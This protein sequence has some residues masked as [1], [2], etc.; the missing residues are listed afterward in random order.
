VVVSEN[1]PASLKALDQWIIWRNETRDGEPTKLPYSTDGPMAKSNDRSTWAPFSAALGV[2]QKGGYS[3]VGF[4]FSPEDEFCGIDLDGCRDPKTG[5]WSQWARDIVTAFSTYCELS[6]SESGVKLFVRGK[7]PL[8]SGKNVKLEGVESRGGKAA[9]I[10]VYDKLR[11][12]AVTGRRIRGMPPE[13]QGRQAL[14]DEYCAK[15]FPAQAAPAV[16]DFTGDAAVADRAR[17]YI[18]KIPPSV[19]GQGGHNQAWKAAC[20][21]VLHFGLNPNEAYPLLA[22]WNFGCQPPWSERELLHKLADADRQPGERGQLRNV[23]TQR[24][25]AVRVADP[26]PPARPPQSVTL[27]SSAQDYLDALK[28]GKQ[29]LISTGMADVDYAIGGGIERGEFVVIA[30]RPSHGKSAV[31]L[32]AAYSMAAEHNPVL[33]VSEEMGRLALGKRAIQ[34]ASDIP[35]EHW[36]HRSDV[37]KSH[38]AEHFEGREPIYI[39]E[40]CGTCDRAVAAIRQHVEQ[41]GVSCVVVDY[42]QLLGSK[43]GNRYEQ[44]THTSVALRQAASEFK[45][46]LLVLCQL[47]R[48][49]ESRDKF[50]PKMSDLRESGQIEQDADVVM[51][52]VWPHRIDS[53]KDP[54]EFLVYVGKN[55][56][57]PINAATV[58][59]RFEPSRQMV[60]MEKATSA[61]HSWTNS[62]G[63]DVDEQRRI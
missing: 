39:V 57:R 41:H 8:A 62:G 5:E 49:I 50:W 40:S 30:A 34:F 36:S 25:N 14:L 11:Y 42:G 52:L 35:Q 56:N 7:C 27:E 26:K 38:L 10:E 33:I 2:F 63:F 53:K 29:T 19:S 28:A 54:H 6:P 47:S 46:V 22:E 59:C 24:W 37:V 32:Q 4:V 16:T 61:E 20:A 58:T 1:I 55:R 3:G 9:G 17:K 21:L 51:F 23:Q 13:P 12:F 45:I 48:A 60:L 44:V 15:W 31:G 43:G 18:A